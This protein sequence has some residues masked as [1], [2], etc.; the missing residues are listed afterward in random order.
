MNL[1]ID[2]K[3]LMNFNVSEGGGE[4]KTGM[5]FNNK[6]VYVK[7]IHI[8]NLSLGTITNYLIH[9]AESNEEVLYWIGKNKISNSDI[10]FTI[11][12]VYIPSDFTY[13]EAQEIYYSDYKFYT[14][15]TLASGSTRKISDIYL[16]YFYTKTT[17]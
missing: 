1:S 15:I 5:I 4:I 3:N 6:P 13:E 16:L 12:F 2:N 14:N 11:P 8:S 7:S 17:D 10:Y 9:T